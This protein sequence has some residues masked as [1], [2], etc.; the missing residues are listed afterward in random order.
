MGILRSEAQDGTGAGK[1][2]CVA[3]IPLEVMGTRVPK[4]IDIVRKTL[5]RIE[6]SADPQR[7]QTAVQE[8]KSSVVLS[9]AEH[10]IRAA[11]VQ[12]GPEPEAGNVAA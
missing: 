11:S 9:I 4:L 12:E 5:Q 8:L 1:P 10:E 3:C 6:E 2:H 7:E